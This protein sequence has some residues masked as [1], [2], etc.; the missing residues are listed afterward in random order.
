MKPATLVIGRS[1]CSVT[2]A[3]SKV[4]GSSAFSMIASSCCA[5]R[6]LKLGTSDKRRAHGVGAEQARHEHQRVD[7]DGD[8][9]RQ[10][11]E[12]V[13]VLEGVPGHDEAVGLVVAVEL[14]SVD[15][16]A[17]LV[18]LLAGQA[19]V[20]QAL[21]RK[22]EELVGALVGLELLA[23][24]ARRR[25]R[26]GAG[27]ERKHQ[28]CGFARLLGI[29]VDAANASP[30]SLPCSPWRPGAASTAA[31]GSPDARHRASGGTRP[32]PPRT[33]Q[34]CARDRGARLPRRSLVPLRELD[35]LL[36][37]LRL[38]LIGR[39][40]AVDSRELAVD[41]GEPRL[42]R[43]QALL[44]VAGALLG[45]LVGAPQLIELVHALRGRRDP[46]PPCRCLP[47]PCP[48]PS[49]RRAWRRSRA[50]WRRGRSSS[51]RSRRQGLGARRRGARA[52]R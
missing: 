28:A 5:V 17:Q 40:V 6:A 11:G 47:R 35:A 41:L 12:P 21:A 15:L 3:V 39:E 19:G 37:R 48:R 36:G 2:R 44:G 29:A 38:G 32:S 8:R 51:A 25:E 27:V 13:A 30:W 43:V 23:A 49:P 1:D 14:G 42:D 46:C 26:P 33:R 10:I 16:G 52:R 31:A 18:G 20:R 50:P 7:G 9:Q 4:S 45:D 22:A 24:R 34:G